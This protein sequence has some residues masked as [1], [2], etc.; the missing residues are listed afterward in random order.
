M[1]TNTL[2]SQGVAAVLS[3]VAGPLGID[4]FYVGAT[5][6]GIIQLLLTICIIG[7]PISVPWA[8]IS[9]S[10]L[11]VAILSGTTPVFYPQVDWAPV[12]KRDKIFAYII[13]GVAVISFI[14]RLFR[15]NKETYNTDDKKKKQTNKKNKKTTCK[16]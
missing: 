6:Y 9:T 3:S 15:K 13:I 4:K 5:T 8:I 12:N 11:L 1:S 2:P 10:V 16:L 14:S 7:I